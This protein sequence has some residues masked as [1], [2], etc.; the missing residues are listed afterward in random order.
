MAKYMRKDSDMEY[1]EGVS[2]V[3]CDNCY[4]TVDVNS[5][6]CSEINEFIKDEGWIVSNICGDYYEFC[7]RDCLNKFRKGQYNP[8]REI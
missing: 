5:L 7:G 1:G 2:V 8:R 6:V 4:E 3:E